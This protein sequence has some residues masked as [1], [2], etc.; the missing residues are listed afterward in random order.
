[1]HRWQQEKHT[2]IKAFQAFFIVKPA[3]CQACGFII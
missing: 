2:L 1:M 3:R